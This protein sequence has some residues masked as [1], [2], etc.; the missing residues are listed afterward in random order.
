M[1]KLGALRLRN[2]AQIREADL[3]FGDFTVL[4]GPQAS[5]KSLALALLKLAI[6][7]KSVART[8]RAYDLLFN[9]EREFL[10]RYFGEGA[11][12]V[13]NDQTE[14]KWDGVEIAPAT[15]AKARQ[16]S[17]DIH[18]A[19]YYIPAH[20]TLVL[21]GGY[22]PRFQQHTNETP[23]VVR[24]FSEQVREVLIQSR[25][26]EA[27]FPHNRR[28]K[29]LLKAKLDEA[30]F[31]GAQLRD[32]HQGSQ[33]RLVLEAGEQHLSYMTWTAGQREVIPLI[34][35]SYYLLPAGA[36]TKRESV[37]WVVIEEPE[38]GLHPRGIR[39]VF[40]LALDLLAR[41]Y[42]VVLSTHSPLVL[43]LVWALR[44]LKELKADARD[45]LR[46]FGYDKATPAAGERRMA[47]EAL[48][49]SYHTHLMDFAPDQ[50]VVSRDISSL[51]PSSQ[52]PAIAGWGGLT[53]L[54]SEI[55]EV[56][57]D[58]VNRAPRNVR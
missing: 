15:I 58:V 46:L 32:D 9:G 57:A 28:L 27:L 17:G 3:T 20:R 21:A 18:H 40:L 2:F 13:W 25:P 34:L 43:D 30:I 10:D 42:K 49:R 45:V 23:F 11:G 36:A 31:H 1:G 35:G 24:H 48:T 52:D 26:G 8:C 50:R 4:V 5:G 33:R 19:L 44:K 37:D 47:A 41:G 56:I 7:G 29:G 6:D 14:V 53:G 51:D 22:P 54:S 55:A 12:S 38:M 16:V 39:A